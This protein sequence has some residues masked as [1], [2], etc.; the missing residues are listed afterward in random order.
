MPKYKNAFFDELDKPDEEVTTEE[1][2]EQ[3]DASDTP[4]APQTDWEKRYSDLRR[5]SQQKQEELNRR[6]EAMETQ[7]DSATKQQIKFPKT[8]EEIKAWSE[9]YPEV[10]AIVDTIARKR[11]GEVAEETEKRLSKLREKEVASERKSAYEQ[12]LSIHP[13]FDDIKSD[14]AFSEWVAEQPSYIYDALYKNA[15]DVRAASR[16]IDL[17][18]VDTKKGKRASDP[19]KDAARD[20]AGGGSST[21]KSTSRPK[22]SDS[23]VAALSD[24]DYDKYE[25]EIM[26][27]MRSGNYTYDKK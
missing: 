19:N 23:R 18:K 26:E 27:A 11:A 25:E 20:V 1:N 8:E 15:T 16:A 12:L 21:P 9:K 17:Y 7:L 14:P 5:H 22:W 10:A 4:A 2:T 24:R 13:D 6:L 3:E